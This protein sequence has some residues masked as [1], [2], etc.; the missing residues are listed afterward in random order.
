MG[1]GTIRFQNR[2][3]RGTV[4]WGLFD[5]AALGKVLFVYNLSQNV[6]NI[7]KINEEGQM[8]VLKLARVKGQTKL[9]RLRT[10]HLLNTQF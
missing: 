1:W 8:R 9:C 3:K 6:E 7:N 4:E 5:F 10:S 2:W